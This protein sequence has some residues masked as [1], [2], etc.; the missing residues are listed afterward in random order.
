MTFPPSTLSADEFAALELL[1]RQSIGVLRSAMLAAEALRLNHGS[2]TRTRKCL[3]LGRAALQAEQRTVSFAHAAEAALEARR[4]RRPRTLSDFR[5]LSKR[6]LTRC[7]G[8]ARR[9]VRGI[10]PAECETYLRQ[11]FDTPR[12]RAKGH[13]TLSAIFHTARRSG[14]CDTNPMQAVDKPRLREKEIRILSHSEIERLLTTAAQHSGGSCLPAVGLMLYAGLRPNEV[15]RLH[16]RDVHLRHGCISIH[17]Q[18]SKTGGARLVTIHPPL[19][20]LLRG[21]EGAAHE[22]ICPRSWGKHWREL[23]RAAG[24]T[25]WQPD[26][27]RHT[28]ASHHLASFRSYPALQLEMGHRSA[29]LLRTRYV[30]MPTGKL[31]FQRK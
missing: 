28:F 24:F 1:R 18:H 9:R 16:W 23:H 30:S 14:W 8:L 5:Y 29:A 2:E 10:T 25:P 19:L 3:A 21:R 15:A 13:A 20:K 17:P 7:P 11:A 4:D 12:Q 31:I 27:L 6:L 22:R 26:V